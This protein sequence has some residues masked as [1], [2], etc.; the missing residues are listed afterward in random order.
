MEPDFPLSEYMKVNGINKGMEFSRLVVDRALSPDE[1][2]KI[3]FGFFQ[4]FVEYCKEAG[5]THIY[6][7]T[8]P[9]LARKWALPGFRQIGEEFRYPKY[10]E[11]PWVV[12]ME[13]NIK[14]AYEQ[15][16]KSPLNVSKE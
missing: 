2:M 15:Y 6:T 8:Y 3:L 1:R 13:C 10:K 9:G 16:L 11:S 12:P 14:Q 4:C 7:V 5:V